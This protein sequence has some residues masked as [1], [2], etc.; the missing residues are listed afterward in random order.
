M[1]HTAGSAAVLLVVWALAGAAAVS[2][3]I[4]DVTL[5]GAT[6]TVFFRTAGGTLRGIVAV[7]VTNSGGAV[8]GQFH[9]AAGGEIVTTAV[10]LAAGTATY[11]AHVRAIWPAAADPQ[12]V[13]S[14]QVGAAVTSLPSMTL[15]VHRPFT[16]HIVMDKHLDWVW[17]YPTEAATRDAMETL[18][19]QYLDA[20]ETDKASA[21]FPAHEQTHFSLDQTIW[22]DAWKLERPAEEGRLAAAEA[23][24]HLGVGALYAVLLTG[25]LGTEEMIR[26]LYPAR[27]L[28]RSFGIDVRVAVPM[29]T[30]SI[31]WGLATVAAGAGV[32]FMVKG[33]CAC[34]G[35]VAPGAGLG[36]VPL[37]RWTGPDGAS[38]LLKWDAFSDSQFF[39]GYAECYRLWADG[40]D[41]GGVTPAQE[42][43][44]L[45]TIARFEAAG[46][47]YPLDHVML[48]GLGWDF[49]T[50]GPGRLTATIRAWNA[51]RAAAGHEY[52]KLRNSRADEFFAAAEASLQSHGTAVPAVSG[53]FGADWEVWM[54]YHA[55]AYARGRAAREALASAESLSALAATLDS[56]HVAAHQALVAEAWRRLMILVEH[57][58]ANTG[59]FGTAFDAGPVAALK[60]DCASLAEAHAAT[61]LSQSAALLGAAVR[62][63]DALEGETLLVLN[64]GQHTGAALVEAPVPTPGDRVVLDPVSGVVLPSQIVGPTGGLRVRFRAPELPGFGYRTFRVA[65]GGAG[66]PPGVQA[67]PVLG[68]IENEFY[69]ITVSP[70]TG[71][72]TSIF[73][74]TRGPRELLASGGGAPGANRLDVNGQVATSAQ[75]TA[76][77]VG[78]VSG[79]LRIATAVLGHTCTATIT[80]H[81]GVDRIDVRND[82]TRPPGSDPAGAV[83]FGFEWNLSSVQHRYEAGA[84]IT[85]P[86]RPDQ[87]PPGDHLPGSTQNYFA[88]QR[89]VDTTGVDALGAPGGVRVSGPDSYLF[90]PGASPSW[91]NPAVASPRITFLGYDNAPANGNLGLGDQADET[92]FVF[93]FALAGYAGPFDGPAAARFALAH[94]REPVARFLPADQNGSLPADRMQFVAV[95]D[96]ALVTAL[97]VAEEGPAGGFIVRLWDA[98]FQG[99]AV[100]VAAG[101]LEAGSCRSTDLLERDQGAT[102]PCEG[103]S[104][105]T[106]PARGF[107]TRRLLPGVANAPP[108]AVP[109][110]PQVVAAGGAVLLDGSQSSDPDDVPA[111][112]WFQISGKR[113]NLSGAGSAVAGFTAPQVASAAEGQLV[114]QLIVDDGKHRPATTT[115]SVTVLPDATPP[116]VP[117]SLSATAAGQTI[118]LSWDPA[119][120]PESGIAGY[121]IYRASGAGAAALHATV[122]NVLVF[123]DSGLPPNQPFTYT[124]R[125]L[126]G[127][128]L[129]GPPSAPAAATTGD[130]PP[131]PPASLAA[132]AG[133]GM[134]VLSWSAVAVPDL[135][136]YRVYRSTGP[137]GPWQLIHDGGPAT[138]HTDTAVANGTSYCYVAR[139]RDATQESGDSPVAC[140]LPL[141]DPPPP[142]A[143]LTAVPGHHSVA[144]SWA[145]VAAPDLRGYR[146]Y[147]SITGAGPWA[148]VADTGIATSF[149]DFTVVNGSTWSWVVRAYDLAQESGDSPV[150]TATAT[151]QGGATLTIAADAFDAT[152][153]LDVVR[154]G[155]YSPSDRADYV[156]ND[157]EVES[158]GM[159]FALPVPPGATILS[160]V[161]T[162]KAGNWQN[163][164]P[165]GAMS[166]R[167]YDVADAD[168]FVDQEP[169]DLLDHHPAAP[170][171]VPWAAGTA[172]Q[173]GTVHG[174]PSLVPLVQH[175]VDRP[176]WNAGQRIGFVLTEGTLGAG[177]Y[178]G[179]R[180]S[181]AGSGEGPSLAVTWMSNAP[182]A[183]SLAVTPLSLGQSG[184]ADITAGP[185]GG[186]FGLWVSLGTAYVPVP[187]FG[188][189]LI[190]LALGF[191]LATGMLDGAG[192]AHVPLGV[193]AIPALQGLALTWQ[194]WVLT[195]PATP[196][197]GS[198]TNLVVR[199][200][201][202]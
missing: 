143:S 38:V 188:N 117:S 194:A 88:C 189:V 196:P 141:D 64:P 50:V 134:V 102:M 81:A 193:P 59:T 138:T 178:Y 120:D 185:A 25:C 129:E 14:L 10:S 148:I 61:V 7:T 100:T 34:A 152:S 163:P 23:T 62:T 6:E 187:P 106:V 87:L 82:V 171:M 58:A 20:I 68:V 114:F 112:R 150:A 75:I 105:V 83:R 133:A 46:G 3:Q 179:F 159:I 16:I 140:A 192:A 77:E 2:A 116:T 118:G 65:G 32:S 8:T 167:V 166:I 165:T 71:A 40:N 54:L 122:G 137:A 9:V 31:P 36:A 200:I 33:L 199:V 127:G 115:A 162:V 78:P 43:D 35:Q 164:D 160:A 184:A 85:R 52:P 180:D 41:L 161:V 175:I 144:L 12:A 170:A 176:D 48:Y 24:G 76:F 67:D 66:A 44:I 72:M 135:T 4:P 157:F 53:C 168:P 93:R 191:E 182:P 173:S 84:A 73:D 147:R 60:K 111:F 69:R 94:V 5:A 99:A 149:T 70:V 98:G 126:N 17:Q 26:A 121:R 47:A 142:P 22:W 96:A 195:P 198:L 169:I 27:A 104:G 139:S 89:W 174:T 183:A 151:G 57:T 90:F 49:W 119:S 29:E 181:A 95:D 63:G 18:L 153:V 28:E 37:F 107:A 125:A 79:S 97:K 158:A 19:D 56:G 172:W 108:V 110:A 132:L 201:G 109:P 13:V 42:Q 80:L 51:A 123:T 155:G 186:S 101:A 156:S 128:G 91:N 113:V 146:I 190:D 45:A 177:R 131:P 202:S 130:D 39:G 74:K 103:S 145:A 55:A 136:G 11:E 154:V 30:D 197:G 124:V 92:D 86:G 21:L 1:R 15:G